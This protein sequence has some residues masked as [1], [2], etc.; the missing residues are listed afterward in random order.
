MTKKIFI[1][2][3]T[4]D[5]ALVEALVNI[6]L[7][8]GCQIDR[9]DI[10]CSSIEGMGTLSGDP[11]FIRDLKD[12]L[13]E[14]SLIILLL[15]PNYYD[16]Q[17]C[18]AELG[19]TWMLDTRTFPIIVPPLKVGEIKGIL[20]VTQVGSIDDET[21]L[22]RLRDAATTS[23]GIPNV[24]SDNW[25]KRRIAFSD[26]LSDILGS[27][28]VPMRIS[29]DALKRV[30]ERADIYK[31]ELDEANSEIEGLKVLIAELEKLKDP[32]DVAKVKFER[33][34]EHQKFDDLRWEVIVKLRELPKVVQKA[35]YFA[36]NNEAY[37]TEDQEEDED[38]RSAVRQ[39][40]LKKAAY[41][42]YRI[43][44]GRPD[45][46]AAQR[47]VTNL[48]LFLYDVSEEFSNSFRDKHGYVLSLRNELFW[49][50]YI[51]SELDWP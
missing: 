13:H 35:F 12:K 25:L 7:D 20:Q 34:S 37:A 28:P 6:L 3:S 21:H 24:N 41:G 8:N 46:E 26:Q 14:A 32:E 2:H 36:E 33:L 51:F 16:S 49:S 4:Q 40:Y 43:E 18:L 30:Q 10:Y 38:A 31:Q 27:L 45:V 11:D 23:S 29:P 42:K 44:T 15:S 50:K 47:A 39:G 19:A 22:E 5:K 48:S 1:S 9:N 17:Y